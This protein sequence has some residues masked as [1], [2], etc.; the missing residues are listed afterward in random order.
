MLRLV[1]VQVRTNSY[2][3]NPMVWQLVTSSA[4]KLLIKQL[5]DTNP[6]GVDP[7]SGTPGS[8]MLI[9]LRCIMLLSLGSCFV[10][11]SCLMLFVLKGA[12]H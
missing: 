11:F 12:Y 4:V 5:L 8:H 3:R 10:I 7:A 1:T 2:I 9:P 6:P